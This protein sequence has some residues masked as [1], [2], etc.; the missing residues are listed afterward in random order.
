M[1]GALVSSVAQADRADTAVWL[2]GLSVFG[3]RRE[4]R[5]PVSPSADGSGRCDDVSHAHWLPPLP[6]SEGWVVRAERASRI[7]ASIIAFHDSSN[8]S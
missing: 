6:P 8:S 4:W 7:S 1:L 3:G 5:V 2:S